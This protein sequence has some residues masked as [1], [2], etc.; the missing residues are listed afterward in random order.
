ML[1]CYMKSKEERVK[2][3]EQHKNKIISARGNIGLKFRNRTHEKRL[4]KVV[5][6]TH[7]TINDEKSGNTLP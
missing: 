5:K 4:S 7:S 2:C 1:K 6:H 3:E